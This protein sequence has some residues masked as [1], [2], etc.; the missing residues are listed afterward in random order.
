M[1]LLF[2]YLVTGLRDND[3]RT[4]MLML[5]A[6]GVVLSAVSLLLHVFVT[7]TLVHDYLHKHFPSYFREVET[8]DSDEPLYDTPESSSDIQYH[9]HLQGGMHV[10]AYKLVRFLSVLALLGFSIATF[11]LGEEGTITSIGKWSKK[12]RNANLYSNIRYLNSLDT[13]QWLQV[14]MILTYVFIDPSCSGA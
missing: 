9:I 3:V 4:S 2:P 5:P 10:F 13:D 1:Q 14:A 7:S 11:I 12:L 6:Y 8:T